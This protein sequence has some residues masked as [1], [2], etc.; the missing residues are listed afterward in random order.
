MKESQRF[1]EPV[2]TE[3]NE[4]EHL[5]QT[6]IS[7]QCCFQRNAFRIKP[8]D[9]STHKICIRFRNFIALM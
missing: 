8:S 7:I 4:P 9:Y 5:T 6:K 2:E 1:T 3:I